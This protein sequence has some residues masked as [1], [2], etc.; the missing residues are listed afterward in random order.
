MGYSWPRKRVSGCGGRDLSGRGGARLARGL[1]RGLAGRA[2]SGVWGTDEWAEL[3]AQGQAARAGAGEPRVE[4]RA[5]Q[6]PAPSATQAQVLHAGEG[7]SLSSTGSCWLC[8]GLQHH[9][10]GRLSVRQTWVQVQ[11]LPP[12]GCTRGNI[13][14]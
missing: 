10:R 7:A 9:L 2:E 11:A 6:H 12:T 14:E 4:S 8:A 13:T 5:S 1:G 3:E